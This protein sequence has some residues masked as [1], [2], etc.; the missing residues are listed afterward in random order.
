MLSILTLGLL[1]GM[2]HTIEADHLA[3]VATLTSNTKTVKLA[4]RQGALWGIGHTLTLFIFCSVVLFFNTSIPENTASLLEFVVGIM[5]LVLGAD[6]LRKTY[7]K[8]IH[9]HTHEHPSTGKHF[10]AHSH[11]KGEEHTEAHEH[12]HANNSFYKPLL[13]GMMHGMAGTAALMV[14]VFQSVEGTVAALI[15]TVIF[16][17]GSILGMALLS[18]TI[19][20]PFMFSA[21]RMTR[22]HNAMH[23]SLGSITMCIGLMVAIENMPVKS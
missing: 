4:V 2:R 6:M 20:V 21:S 8:R 10:H 11:T 14:L 16:G 1:F 22:L 18:V 7:K 13:I 23:Y 19:A 15:Y 17:V 9:F 3:A 12:H 5:L